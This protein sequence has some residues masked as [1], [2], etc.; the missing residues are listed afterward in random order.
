MLQIRY[1]PYSTKKQF[2]IRCSPQ[3]T[4]ETNGERFIAQPHATLPPNKQIECDAE[5]ENST[6][7]RDTVKRSYGSTVSNLITINSAGL[8]QHKTVGRV[9][10]TTDEIVSL[11]R[12]LQDGLCEALPENVEKFIGLLPLST[13]TISNYVS[14]V[15]H[16][17]HY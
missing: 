5:M 12:C 3:Q 17:L 4:T 2:S 9:P 14:I 7:Q 8:Q 15:H 11:G 16:E 1:K 13:E 10:S 6:E